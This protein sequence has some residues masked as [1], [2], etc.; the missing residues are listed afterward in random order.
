MPT[1]LE[2]FGEGVANEKARSDDVGEPLMS[3][4]EENLGKPQTNSGIRVCSVG[5]QYCNENV[6]FFVKLKVFFSTSLLSNPGICR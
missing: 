4:V 6:D 3:F 1:S 2:L 5:L